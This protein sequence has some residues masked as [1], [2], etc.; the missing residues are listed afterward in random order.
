[1]YIGRGGNAALGGAP[2]ADAAPSPDAALTAGRLVLDDAKAAL[3]RPGNDVIVG[4]R[5]EHLHLAAGD[6]EPSGDAI[7]GRVHN[8]EWLGHEAVIAVDVAGSTIA[9]R[10]RADREL[11][12]VGADVSLAPAPGGVH[13]FDPATSERLG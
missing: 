2:L 12:D 5:P 3:V 13:L 7:S 10:Q 11:P 4:V 9:V 8:V 6:D 1:V